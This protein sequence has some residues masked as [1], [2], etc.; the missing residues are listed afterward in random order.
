MIYFLSSQGYLQ[1]GGHSDHDENEWGWP[2]ARATVDKIFSKMDKNKDDQI[3]TV[4]N[5]SKL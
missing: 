5:Y 4:Q 2:H 3:T 1:N